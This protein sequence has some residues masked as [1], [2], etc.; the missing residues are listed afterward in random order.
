MRCSFYVVWQLTKFGFKYD[1]MTDFI[2][3]QNVD[4]EFYKMIRI[5]TNIERKKRRE[6]CVRVRKKNL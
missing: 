2:P 3:K 6:I 1:C 5:N 4:L